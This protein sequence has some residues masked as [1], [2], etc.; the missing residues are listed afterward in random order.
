MS[1]R[2]CWNDLRLSDYLSL[3][4]CLLFYRSVY[5]SA[6]QSICLPSL[7]LLFFS[8]L[9]KSRVLLRQCWRA[10]KK[11]NGS[12]NF[13]NLQQFR[14]ASFAMAIHLR[15]LSWAPIFK[16]R[17]RFPPGKSIA[18]KILIFRAKALMYLCGY[19]VLLFHYVM[20]VSCSF[21]SLFRRQPKLFLVILEV[22]PDERKKEHPCSFHARVK[23]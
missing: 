19:V 4:V 20:S 18:K 22:S 2:C 23:R 10:W 17:L 3:H 5:L 16:L 8:L 12:G 13:R 9:H 15:I 14:L 21:A 1:C 11:L 7:H 6:V